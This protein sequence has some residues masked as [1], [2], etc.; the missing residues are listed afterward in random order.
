MR[1]TQRQTDPQYQQTWVFN[2]IS[3]PFCEVTT[4]MDGST[5]KNVVVGGSYTQNTHTNP[6]CWVSLGVG[7]VHLT[8]HS[9][10]SVVA[11]PTYSAGYIPGFKWINPTYPTYT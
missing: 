9:N 1:E 4:T 11:H 5:Q 6:S 10:L 3:Q 7:G 8:D 2:K